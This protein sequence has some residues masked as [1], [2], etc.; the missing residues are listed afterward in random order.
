MFLTSDFFISVITKPAP[1]RT[2]ARTVTSSQNP[3]AAMIQAVMVVPMLAP[4]IT[5]MPCLSDRVATLTRLATNIVVALDDWT[6]A[7]IPAPER[8]CLNG[9]PEVI[10]F[11]KRLS[12][13]PQ[14]F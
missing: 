3:V 5:Q 12:L 11:S 2:N 7:V 4:I 1:S 10:H 6:T 14:D 8:I 9:V 13:S